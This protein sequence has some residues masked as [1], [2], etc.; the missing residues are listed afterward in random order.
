MT[1][2]LSG[3]VAL[4][5]MNALQSTIWLEGA[6]PELFAQLRILTK[7]YEACVEEAQGVANSIGEVLVPLKSLSKRQ[8]SD[9]LTLRR[10]FHA[11][12]C[13]DQS[14]LDFAINLALTAGEADLSTRI[15]SCGVAL[16]AVQ[17]QFLTFEDDLE[18][19][20][21]RLLDLPSTLAKETPLIRPLLHTLGQAPSP[22]APLK[23]RRRYLERAWRLIT[24]AA[25]EA[26]P[27]GWMSHVGWVKINTPG[28]RSDAGLP[29]V[30]G[31]AH[32]QHT[33]SVWRGILDARSGIADD[34]PNATDMFSANPLYWVED[35]KFISVIVDEDGEPRCAITDDN[36]ILQSVLQVL[37]DGP[38]TAK[39]MF[40]AL[41]LKT[42]TV[43]DALRCFLRNLADN[44]VIE[45]CSKPGSTAFSAPI[46][47]EVFPQ[48]K[49]KSNWTDVFRNV[50]GAVPGHVLD[51]LTGNLPLI[52]KTLA[53]FDPPYRANDRTGQQNNWSVTDVLKSSIASEP[54]IEAAAPSSSGQEAVRAIE[55]ARTSVI[56]QLICA[57]GAQDP[58]HLD[59]SADTLHTRSNKED[60]LSWPVDLVVRVGQENGLPLIF[61]KGVWPA[62]TIDSRYS[63]GMTEFFGENPW[64]DRYRSF[65][66]DLEEKTDYTFVE[67]LAPPHSDRADNAV[68]RPAYTR[69]WTGH[70]D[71]GQFLSSSYGQS[72]YIAPKDITFTTN[73][74]GT[75]CHANGKKLWPV[76][77][78]TRTTPPPWNKIVKVLSAAMPISVPMSY[79]SVRRLIAKGETRKSWPRVTLGGNIVICPQI[80]TVTK[81]DLWDSTAPMIEKMQCLEALKTRLGLPRWLEAGLPGS[82]DLL[83]IDLESVLAIQQLEKMAATSKTIQIAEKL[84]MPGHQLVELDNSQGTFP[85]EAELVI[86]C[87]PENTDRIVSLLKRPPKMQANQRD[88]QE[89]LKQRVAKSDGR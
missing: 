65:L 66:I 58:S 12:R 85:V 75:F 27:R 60:P 56:D 80:W 79:Q 77:H 5:R 42:D 72:T 28:D 38:K 76:Y 83:T 40:S 26:T 44:G 31:K 62:G 41:S 87:Y 22:D 13:P 20:Q 1:Q 39:H 36:D 48:P 89:V 71:A 51:S 29:R 11:A 33:E 68:R 23:K 52:L 49:D 73:P 82:V 9:V 78:A 67:V 84:P 35:G 69:H 64:Q 74:V 32:V 43:R 4:V 16:V 53:L 8:R 45:P 61:L 81:A 46:D 57:T 15:R 21:N 30:E 24:R 88:A 25:C 19:E 63:D 34:W 47:F 37:S 14:L 55:T 54:T 70:A 59:I 6:N 7:T 86:R 17:A 10:D 50:S 3:N 2:D 18:V